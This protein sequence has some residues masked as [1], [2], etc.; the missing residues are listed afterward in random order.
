MIIRKAEKCDVKGILKLLSQV[1]ELHAEIRPDIFIS[2]TVKYAKEE[3]F[4][5]LKDE[6]RVTYVALDDNENVLGYAMC[7]IKNQPFSNT[8]VPFKTL[9]ID[10]FCV[11]K[12][13]R[14]HHIGKQLFE[15]VKCRAKE[16]DCYEIT[17]NVWEGNEAAKAFYN[18]MGMKPKETEMELV[19]GE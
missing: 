3:L 2:G 16:L 18:K 1:L 11:D 15:Y 13:A 17:L 10:D 19:L 6:N 8:M 14:G 9:F 5:I 7:I 12:D 4:D